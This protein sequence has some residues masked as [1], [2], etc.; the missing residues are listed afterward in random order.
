MTLQK[1]RVPCRAV[2]SSGV[3]AGWTA[4]PCGTSKALAVL[5]FF[6]ISSLS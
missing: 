3:P 5:S 2:T 6:L 4:A 1:L